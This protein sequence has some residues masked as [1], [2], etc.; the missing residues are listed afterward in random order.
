MVKFLLTLIFATT[1]KKENHPWPISKY[2]LHQ[3][4]HHTTPYYADDGRHE[5]N[6]TENEEIFG[7][8]HGGL[9]GG[10]AHGRSRVL[11]GQNLRRGG[12]FLFFVF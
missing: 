4:L 1:G 10:R 12:F 3:Q 7:S 11:E 6:V 5:I 8:C 2:M 9:G